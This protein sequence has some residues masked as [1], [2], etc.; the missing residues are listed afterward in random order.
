MKTEDPW[1]P[2][3]PVR[4]AASAN[5]PWSPAGAAAAASSSE[6]DDFDLLT[7]R[8]QA[9]SP[10]GRS[11]GA[12]SPFDLSGMD[13]ALMGG[14]QHNDHGG[15]KPK[16]SPESFLGPNSNLVN[17][18]N[19]V[20]SYHVIMRRSFFVFRLLSVHFVFLFYLFISNFHFF[21]SIFENDDD[22]D[23]LSFNLSIFRLFFNLFRCR[24]NPPW[25]LPLIH[26][27]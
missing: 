7:N 27:L 3:P 4:T 24:P 23:Y 8:T 14:S 16:K 9:A 17:L 20:K 6:V 12:S 25:L 11:N 5:D 15:A 21:L 22:E 2:Q 1:S 18:E 13:S 10:L 26:S 19:L